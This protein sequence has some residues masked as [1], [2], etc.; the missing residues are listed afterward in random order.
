MIRS[1]FRVAMVL[2]ACLT[3]AAPALGGGFSIFE[4]GSKAMGMAGAFT[5]QADD[6]SAL[7]HNVGGLAFTERRRVAVGA[8]WIQSTDESFVGEPP[9]LAT[10]QSGSLESLAEL[11]PHIY[12]VQ[13]VNPRWSFGL[14]VNSPFGLKTEWRDPDVFAGRFLNTEASLLVIDVSPNVGVKISERLGVGFGLVVRSS[15]VELNRRLPTFDPLS[16]GVVDAAAVAIESDMEQGVGWQAGLLYRYNPSFS[17][18]FSYRSGIE[19][20]YA[21]T[22]RL[23]QIPTGNPPL[24]ELIRATLP[25][26]QDL[27]VESEI[28][29]PATASL[30]ALFAVSRRTKVEIDVNWAGWSSFDVVPIRF[31]SAPLLSGERVEL[32]DDA[33]NYRVGAR[34]ERPSGSEWRMGVVY[35]ESPQPD[36]SVSPLLPDADRVGYTVG[37]GR[38][39]GGSQVDLALMYLD[40]EARST[41]GASRDFFNGTY[42]QTGW[43]FAATVTF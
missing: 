39:F 41:R 11:V 20:E 5:A 23:T 37:W 43:L 12:W 18:G 16:G 1:T 6:P 35:D 3:A 29:F 10:G 13:P 17:L 38:P 8:T 15:E 28:D 42:S 25:L 30:G 40:F 26:D 33:F 36:A 21:G 27:P 7:Y 2:G 24:D 14:A 4:Q 19:V 34:F 31:P 32:W 9:G 22:G